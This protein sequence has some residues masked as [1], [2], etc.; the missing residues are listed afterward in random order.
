VRGSRAQACG[1]WIAPALS[2]RSRTRPLA[3]PAAWRSGSTPGSGTSLTRSGRRL[4][5]PP[6]RRCAPSRIPTEIVCG[7]T[8]TRCW[9]SRSRSAQREADH[10]LEVGDRPVVGQHRRLE[11][12]VAA[13]HRLDHL[14]TDVPGQ[15]HHQLAGVELA[16]G[17]PSLALEQ[18]AEL[19]EADLVAFE[20]G[21][22][23]VVRVG[24]V[25][26][27]DEPPRQP[28]LLLVAG[29]GVEGAVDDY[30]ADVEEG[31]P[32]HPPSRSWAVACHSSVESRRDSWSTRSSSPWN[33]DENSSK[34]RR[35]LKRPKP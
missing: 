20:A 18:P 7:H 2:E 1:C 9:S 21:P 25:Q 35:S 33:I 3:R 22:C 30:P 32:D 27:S 23:V 8:S 11:A 10:R 12:L 6:S 17:G 26:P 16:A 24:E 28:T 4:F 31:G 34:P 13:P 14:G 29:E 15:P 5:S 19:V